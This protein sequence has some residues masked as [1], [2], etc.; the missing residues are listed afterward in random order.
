[1]HAAWFCLWSNSD[2]NATLSG[3]A[4]AKK[5]DG[6]V[7]GVQIAK[8]VGPRVAI[9]R[10]KLGWSQEELAHHAGVHRTVISPLE[11][12][13]KGFRIE[14]IF[15]IAGALGVTPTQL[16][17]GFYWV[18]DGKGGGYFT[19]QPPGPGDE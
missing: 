10:E 8:V 16:L 2:R 9:L 15:C 13:K 18:P 4:G 14:T 3:V 12:G 7:Y 11:L 1:V 19:E 17:D 6:E 5:A